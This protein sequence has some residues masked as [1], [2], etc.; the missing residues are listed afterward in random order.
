[1][2]LLSWLVR[3]F[4]SAGS[5]AKIGIPCLCYRQVSGLRSRRKTESNRETQRTLQASSLLRHRAVAG[6]LWFS[7]VWVALLRLTSECP[8]LCI[9]NPFFSAFRFACFSVCTRTKHHHRS[10]VTA[11]SDPRD[12]WAAERCPKWGRS[13]P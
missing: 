7:V 13:R 11:G 5:R 2:T 6:Q 1:M 10:S 3:K 12:L 8:F 4:L 9:Q